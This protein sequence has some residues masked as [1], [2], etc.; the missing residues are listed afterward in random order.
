[1][2]NSL[3][4]VL[5]LSR[6]ASV[7]EIKKSYRQLALT[8]HPDVTKNDPVKAEQFKVVHHAYTVLS[9]PEQRNQYDRQGGMGGGVGGQGNSF[10][11]HPDSGG[12]NP[13]PAWAR[14]VKNHR[15]KPPKESINVKDHQFDEAVW[16]AWHYGAG[17]NTVI[18]DSVTQKRKYMD[19]KHSEHGSYWAK[20]NEKNARRERAEA[21]TAARAA[22]VRSSPQGASERMQDRRSRRR[23]GGDNDDGGGGG[24]C[25]VS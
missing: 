23:G 15:K 4:G 21:A 19:P 3:Y 25:V 1:M 9:D 17:K 18:K 6:G 7:A 14:G 10:Y 16:K 11:Q 24:S 22:D 13:E 2:S 20:K 8:L 12:L 5:K